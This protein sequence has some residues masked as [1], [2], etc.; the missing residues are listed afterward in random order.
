MGPICAFFFKRTVSSTRDVYVKGEY[1]VTTT[2]LTKLQL[3]YVRL[4]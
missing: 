4:N 1:L 3:K 2:W